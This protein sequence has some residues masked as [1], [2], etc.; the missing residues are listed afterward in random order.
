VKSLKLLTQD[1][2]DAIAA[3]SRSSPRLRQN[4]NFHDLSERV[5]RFINML[6]PNTYVRPHRHLRVPDVNGFEFFL[7]LQGELGIMVMDDQGQ[8]LHR[9]RVSAQ[10]KTRGVEL[11]EGTYHSLIALAPNTA[12]LELKEG[13]YDLRTDKE[14]LTTFPEEG[15]LEAQEQVKR[16]QQD[17]SDLY[18]DRS[19]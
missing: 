17:F 9:E 15:T 13:P 11:A 3:Q 8:T 5:Q 2:L 12:I 4:Y 19:L 18:K 14:F 7:V 10:G 1:L 6:Q 16:W